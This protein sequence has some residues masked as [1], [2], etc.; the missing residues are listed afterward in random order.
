MTGVP[1]AGVSE[2]SR[3]I[4][5]KGQLE[6][7]ES[8]R[9][10]N[11]RLAHMYE[12]ALRAFAAADNPDGLAQCAF[13][14]RELFDKL[15]LATKLEQPPRS[16]P[17]RTRAN[18]VRRAWDRVI[19]SSKAYQPASGTWAGQV[20]GA[21][22]GFLRV[23]ADFVNY[24]ATEMPYRQAEIARVLNSFDPAPGPLPVPH[25]E[26]RRSTFEKLDEYMNSLTHHNFEPSREEFAKQL[27][28]AERF[29]MELVQPIVA[30]RP[31]EDRGVL[32]AVL[33]ENPD[34]N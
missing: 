32:D 19:R 16:V 29:L 8:L 30:P 28:A 33:E 13:S 1:G 23:V 22:S 9:R 18:E 7:L 27:A 11:P 10:L 21:L 20:N 25:V 6:L 14:I 12:G 3:P 17:M 24:M 26:K 31:Y 34:A 2:N 5:D 4:G 15:H